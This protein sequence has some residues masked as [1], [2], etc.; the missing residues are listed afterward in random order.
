MSL[1]QDTSWR[2]QVS[3]QTGVVLFPENERRLRF[4]LDVVFG[5]SIQGEFHPEDETVVMLGLLLEL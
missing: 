1:D 4:L 3:V 5:P 2:P